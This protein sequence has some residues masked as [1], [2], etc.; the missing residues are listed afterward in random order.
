VWVYYASGSNAPGEI[1]GFSDIGQAV[2]V[3]ADECRKPCERALI[4]Q[5]E[6]NRSLRVFIDSGAFAEFGAKKPISDA[7]WRAR[8]G[9][10]ERVAKV[11]GRRV[12]VILPDKI[13]D[14][15]ET[16]RRL[17]RYRPQIARL[18]ATGAEL[19]IV[20]QG[21]EL[22]HRAFETAARKAAG[23]RPGEY[24]AA[25]PFKKAATKYS[26]LLKYLRGGRVPHRIHLLGL[27]PDSKPAGDRPSGEQIRAQLSQLAPGV[28][29]SGDSV[30]L[31]AAVGRQGKTRKLTRAQDVARADVVVEAVSRSDDPLPDF[32]E[33]LPE[34]SAWVR[35]LAAWKIW[36]RSGPEKLRKLEREANNPRARQRLVAARRNARGAGIDLF[37]DRLSL[38]RREA[39]EFYDDPDA[40]IR[41]TDDEGVERWDRDYRFLVG[42]SWLSPYEGLFGEWVA[43]THVQLRKRR[44]VREAFGASDPVLPGF[45]L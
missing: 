4:E 20:L 15:A 33:L 45:G 21:G 9:L 19:A 23:L 39:A 14:Q 38:S 1:R 22:A 29:W 35:D 43:R 6:R 32:Q 12:L 5:I 17:E 2:G 27:G 30:L 10:M 42:E 25:F 16:L 7:Q 26:E 44:A 40:F 13:A 31:R 8:L 24:V 18:K 41:A 34:P 3:A 36:P 28:R 11:G 37:A